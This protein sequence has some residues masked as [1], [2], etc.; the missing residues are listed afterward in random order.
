MGPPGHGATHPIT[1]SPWLET[2]YVG[3]VQPQLLLLVDPLALVVV[4]SWK[5]GV[6]V[7]GDTMCVPPRKARELEGGVGT[8]LA[9]PLYLPRSCRV[10]PR[11]A[12][13]CTPGGGGWRGRAGGWAVISE[14]PP[15]P[16]MTPPTMGK[17]RHRGG[18]AGIVPTPPPA[19][20]HTGTG[21]PTTH[22]VPPKAMP[23]PQLQ[24]SPHSP[25]Q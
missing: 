21:D 9:P 22:W 1:T 19:L 11:R 18:R 20:P 3:E 23:P 10:C 2:T 17:L 16:R 12:S 14:T 8:P 15:P 6:E 25:P 4:G 5:E 7:V 13:R 24:G